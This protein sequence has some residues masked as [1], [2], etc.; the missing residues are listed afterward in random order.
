MPSKYYRIETADGSNKII[1]ADEFNINDH[2][3]LVFGRA[4]HAVLVLRAGEY[5]NVTPMSEPTF[6]GRIKTKAEG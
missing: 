6:Q 4:G 2:G 5:D 3:T 1:K